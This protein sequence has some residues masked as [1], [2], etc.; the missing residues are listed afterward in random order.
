M[1]FGCEAH[2]VATQKTSLF[3]RKEVYQ[4]IVSIVNS[5]FFTAGT[6]HSYTC[7]K[8]TNQSA[9][10]RQMLRLITA[11]IGS[12]SGALTR[13]PPSL[14]RWKRVGKTTP[15]MA[16]INKQN[17]KPTPIARLNVHERKT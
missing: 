3:L 14:R 2:R 8:S 1:K 15:Q 7:S 17:P 12:M 9:T 13:L 11:M 5:K 16:A 6:F 4:V 10:T